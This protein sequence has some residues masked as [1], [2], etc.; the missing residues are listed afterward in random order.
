MLKKIAIAG[1]VAMVSL[2]LPDFAGDFDCSTYLTPEVQFNCNINQIVS[3]LEYERARI[4]RENP[5]TREEGE[6]R[7]NA[8]DAINSQISEMQ[9]LIYS[10]DGSIDIRDTPPE[11]WSAPGETYKSPASRGAFPFYSCRDIPCGYPEDIRGT[12]KGHP[13]KL[14]LH[15]IHSFSMS[16]FSFFLH[17]LYLSYFIFWK[18][19]SSK[20]F[21]YDISVMSTRKR[22]ILHLCKHLKSS[23]F[24]TCC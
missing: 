17:R 24:L 14:F 11:S 5:S 3:V 20:K 23:C 22:I 9:S 19:I 10:D 15:S 2:P 6:A 12:H 1:V 21:F 18:C 16:H 7:W 4:L 13:Y 8:V